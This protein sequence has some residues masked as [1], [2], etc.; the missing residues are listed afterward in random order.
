MRNLPV[1][2][3]SS[4]LRGLISTRRSAMAGASTMA[5]VQKSAGALPAAPAIAQVRELARLA[6]AELTKAHTVIRT[7]AQELD[8]RLAAV[9]SEQEHM[10]RQSAALVSRSGDFDVR[11]TSFNEERQRSERQTA[12]LAQREKQLA[13]AKRE[14]D[15]QRSAFQKE[16]QALADQRGQLASGRD[17]LT[18]AQTQLQRHQHEI[19]Q[20]DSAIQTLEAQLQQ[21]AAEIRST[22]ESLSLLSGQLDRERQQ[23]ATQRQELIAQC[24][25]PPTAGSSPPD[26]TDEHRPAIAT[27]APIEQPMLVEAEYSPVGPQDPLRPGDRDDQF[28]KLRRDARRRVKGLS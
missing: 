1:L 8:A 7:R 3:R 6:V 14:V 20:R 19:A 10:Q 11:V 2:F 24:G 17:E 12:E 5:M 26:R 22:R 15:Q 4:R 27:P 21:Q 28:R 23:L 13:E 25:A 9:A 18:Q 16:C